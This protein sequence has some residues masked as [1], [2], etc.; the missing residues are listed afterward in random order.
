MQIYLLISKWQIFSNFFNRYL[1]NNVTPYDYK[2]GLVYIDKNENGGVFSDSK[3]LWVL[4][5][6]S[7]FIRPGMKRI[8]VESSE[9]TNLEFS[10]Y[11]SDDEKQLVF[12]VQNYKSLASDFQVS[13]D[14][15][16]DY[17]FKAYLTST[18][19]EDNL[20]LVSSGNTGDSLTIPGNSVMTVELNVKQ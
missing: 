8:G 3:M 10:G 14:S 19:E 16:E 13:I 6:Y 11:K 7:R 15:L 1:E 2:D 5:N 12:I 20:K 17:S 4:G 18:G 9:D